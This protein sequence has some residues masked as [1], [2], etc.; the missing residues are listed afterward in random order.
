MEIST[1]LKTAINLKLLYLKLQQKLIKNF[2]M[3]Y[4]KVKNNYNF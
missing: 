4:S 2:R 3:I 1:N